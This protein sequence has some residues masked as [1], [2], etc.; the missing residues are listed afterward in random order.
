MENFLKIFLI[1]LLV[2]GLAGNG[3]AGD[4][5]FDEKFKQFEDEHQAKMRSCW[6]IKSHKAEV[7]C[8]KKQQ[9]KWKVDP[10]RR[11]GKTYFDK[12]YAVLDFKTLEKR[13]EE[14]KVLYKKAPKF[15]WTEKQKPGV[16]HSEVFGA[17][18]QMIERLQAERYR[19]TYCEGQKKHLEE[20][21]FTMERLPE[22][23]KQYFKE[24]EVEERLKKKGLK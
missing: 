5:F 8:E 4:L 18:I 14:L 9:S 16:L 10:R 12:H 1:I 19:V 17:E 11:G 15:S 23:C 6:K 7:E 20:I 13:L 3:V 24:K 21:N 22:V 2:V